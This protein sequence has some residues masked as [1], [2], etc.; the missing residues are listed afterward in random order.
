[1]YEP[2]FPA[3]IIDI[4]V[5]ANSRITDCLVANPIKDFDKKGL[6][7]FKAVCIATTPP[8]KKDNIATIGMDSIIR[9]LISLKI[10]FL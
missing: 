4:K 6:L 7:K 3:I 10:S 9:S 1:M 2:T 5:G 8:I